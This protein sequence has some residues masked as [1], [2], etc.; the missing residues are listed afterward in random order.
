MINQEKNKVDE[1]FKDA[2]VTNDLSATLDAHR[3]ANAAFLIRRINASANNDGFFRP[4]SGGIDTKK[5]ER[6]EKEAHETR[7]GKDETSHKPFPWK[8]QRAEIQST[9]G[10]LSDAEEEHLKL[11]RLRMNLV[12]RLEKPFLGEIDK[13]DLSHTAVLKIIRRC[14]V[15]VKESRKKR[16]NLPRK[17]I[18]QYHGTSVHPKLGIRR[19]DAGPEWI[20][21]GGV[22]ELQGLER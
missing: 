8:N 12:Q 18:L 22:Q 17:D 4:K 14:S 13:N 20:R 2:V 6:W 7:V 15:I 3:D 1:R 16:K 9:L 21:D 11:H 10:S 19:Q 5:R